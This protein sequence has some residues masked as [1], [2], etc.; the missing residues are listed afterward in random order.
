MSARLLDLIA[1]ASG[2][3]PPRAGADRSQVA[4]AQVASA[5][6]GRVAVSLLG[7]PP[8]S[9][10]AATSLGSARSCYVLLDPST[11]RPVMVLGPAPAPATALPAV[12]ALTGPATVTRTVTVPAVVAGTW[13]AGPSGASWGG[14][15]TAGAGEHAV[16]QGS[17]RGTRL[18]GY[19]DWGQAV[20]ALAATR[21][22]QALVQV[23]PVQDRSWT[24]TLTPALRTDGAPTPTGAGA[25]S[26]ALTGRPVLVDVTA[27]ATALLGGAG[28]AAT[29]SGYGAV[30]GV[31]DAMSLTITYETNE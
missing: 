12:P 22:T 11:G 30:S 13:V 7:S 27:L 9:L 3:A 4:V 28:L 16:W 18:T 6:G 20:P 10:P 14:Y 8:V 17:D 1:S 2:D 24:L 25:V 31:G 19:A 23:V 15:D 21:I 5:S 29:G 26:V